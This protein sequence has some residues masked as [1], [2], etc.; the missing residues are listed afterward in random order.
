MSFVVWTRA[1][2]G[3]VWIEC[4]DQ[5]DKGRWGNR[6]GDSD[7]RA[8][9]RG[10]ARSGHTSDRSPVSALTKRVLCTERR[11]VEGAKVRRGEEIK[12]SEGKR[13]RRGFEKSQRA[14]ERSRSTR[15]RRSVHA[16]QAP[17]ACVR[18]C[19]EV[20]AGDSSDADASSP[21][22]PGL[23]WHK[24]PQRPRERAISFFLKARDLQFPILQ[25]PH[26][27]SHESTCSQLRHQR[28]VE[29]LFMTAIPPLSATPTAGQSRGDHLTPAYKSS[30]SSLPST[31]AMSHSIP[32]LPSTSRALASLGQFACRTSPN[33]CSRSAPLQISRQ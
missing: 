9:G 24:R 20:R 29:N 4:G 14:G 17:L 32:S 33:R 15:P 6:R 23:A 16:E 11:A 12:G 7:G 1:R 2:V 21:R 3:F 18:V 13:R 25:Y 5:V 26:R 22:S 27:Y 28:I 31:L 19:V 10:E 8:G 30:A